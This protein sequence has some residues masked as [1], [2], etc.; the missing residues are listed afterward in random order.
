MFDLTWLF[1][2]PACISQ[3]AWILKL[4]AVELHAGDVSSSKHR[5]ACQTILSHLYGQGITEIGGGQAISQFSLQAASENAAIRTVSKS[6]V[7]IVIKWCMVPLLLWTY[8][9]DMLDFI[10]LTIC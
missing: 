2:S 3:R 8:Q 6:K 7:L 1:C 5:E 9:M 4:L 10:M